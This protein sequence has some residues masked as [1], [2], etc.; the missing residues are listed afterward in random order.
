LD[1]NDYTVQ[2]SFRNAPRWDV[3]NYPVREQH[4]GKYFQKYQKY[5]LWFC[6][7]IGAVSV[8]NLF[9]PDFTSRRLLGMRDLSLDA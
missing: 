8:V 4:W 9:W 3:E 5:T 2:I 6:F 1:I 7:R